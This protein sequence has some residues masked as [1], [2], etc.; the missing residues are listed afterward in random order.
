MIGRD[1]SRQ[2]IEYLKEGRDLGIVV[3]EELKFNKHAQTAV[4]KASETLGIIKCTLHSRLSQVTTKLYK[5]LVLPLPEFGM[6]VATPLNKG[7]QQK[8]EHVQRCVIKVVD[9]C[10]NLDYPP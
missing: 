7:D 4:A 8:L 6:F 3:D 5:D 2:L 10:K 9:G 1:G